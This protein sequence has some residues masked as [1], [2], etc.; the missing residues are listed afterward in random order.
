[1]KICLSTLSE[2]F[3]QMAAS[4]EQDEEMRHNFFA[5]ITHELRTPLT[6][7]RA[8][9]EGIIDGIYPPSQEVITPAL[10]QTYLLEKLVNDLRLLALAEAHA[11]TIEPKEIDLK[12]LISEAIELFSARATEL[13]ISLD[14]SIQVQTSPA[15]ADPM[16]V[17]QIIDN[18]LSN[19]LKFSPQNTSITVGTVSLTDYTEIHVLDQ[20]PGVPLEDIGRIFDRFWRKDK[21][22][23][24]SGGGS[25]L[26]LAICKE[27]VELQGGK[28]KAENREGGGLDLSFTLPKLP[29]NKV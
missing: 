23:S 3:N 6:I 7:L 22:R 25:G 10:D 9:L 19:A 14:T 16:R 12:P 21:S 27:L 29:P 17:E 11:L 15:F 1:M 28:I 2:S 4:L 20:G 18:L 13:G 24:R 26:G 8:R 5:D